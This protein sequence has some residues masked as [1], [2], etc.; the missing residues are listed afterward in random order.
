MFSSVLGTF[1]NWFWTVFIISAFSFVARL[2]RDGESDALTYLMAIAMSAALSA[3]VA[4]IR[5]AVDLRAAK[6]RLEPPPM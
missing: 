6:K 2:A 4:G 5:A 3:V 1:K